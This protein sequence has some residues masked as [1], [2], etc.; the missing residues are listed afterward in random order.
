[1]AS[2]AVGVSFLWLFWGFTV[3]GLLFRHTAVCLY[4]GL[5]AYC[6]D[7]RP[8]VFTWFPIVETL[9]W[10]P[11]SSPSLS[12]PFG[13]GFSKSDCKGNRFFLFGKIW[14]TFY[15]T[16]LRPY[17]ALH[18]PRRLRKAAANIKLIW[19]IDQTIMKPFFKFFWKSWASSQKGFQKSSDIYSIINIQPIN[20]VVYN[21][22][23]KNEY[24][25]N[26]HDKG[27]H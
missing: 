26:E 6:W 19:P 9:H 21:T 20:F 22:N 10:M 25:W 18:Y 5:W 23:N 7:A 3:S 12:T 16:S 15:R 27:C 14:S 24:S 17:S 11:T 1:M 2:L 4:S 13:G 8:C